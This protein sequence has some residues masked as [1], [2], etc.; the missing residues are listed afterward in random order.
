MLSIQA[1]LGEESFDGHGEHPPL[2]FDKGPER[3]A[4]VREGA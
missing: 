2:S 4:V 1:L 3:L